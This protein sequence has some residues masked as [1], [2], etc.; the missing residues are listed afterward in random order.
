MMYPT[1]FNE[2]LGCLKSTK[3]KLNVFPDSQ[4]KFY[5]AR[6]V[7]LIH[8]EQFEHELDELQKQGI[9]SPV[10]FSSWAG[11]TRPQSFI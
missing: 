11:M 7:P 8:K 6:T 10:Q 2:E 5:K 4:P 3:V 9:I 1:V